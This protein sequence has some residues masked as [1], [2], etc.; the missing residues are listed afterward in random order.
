M[1]KP[2]EEVLVAIDKNKKI[3]SKAK[4]INRLTDT[5]YYSIEFHSTPHVYNIYPEDRIKYPELSN[6]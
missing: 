4:I 5:I 2:G 1:F 3:Y 6:D